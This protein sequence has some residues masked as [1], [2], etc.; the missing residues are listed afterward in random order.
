MS[1]RNSSVQGVMSVHIRILYKLGSKNV[2]QPWVQLMKLI[3][4]AVYASTNGFTKQVHKVMAGFASVLPHMLLM[5]V[6]LL[7]YVYTSF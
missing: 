5:R 3:T 4:V 7:L 6:Q 1:V 2:A